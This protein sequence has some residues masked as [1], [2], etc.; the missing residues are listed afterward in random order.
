MT[1]CVHQ[2]LRTVALIVAAFV[3][4]G[5]RAHAQTCALP[6]WDGPVT[7]SGV[8][9]SYHGGSGSSA[10]G[11]TSISVASATGLRTNARALRAGDL[12][13]IMQMQDGTT[14][15]NA[16]QH[17]YAQ[18]ISIAGNVLTLNRTLTNS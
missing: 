16:G 13:L 7:V 14:P 9:N 4:F 18:I 3:I 6:G 17:E 15:A 11:A 5:T 10:A 1:F 2:F 12:V 8:V